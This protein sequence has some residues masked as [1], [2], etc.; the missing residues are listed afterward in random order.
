MAAR[1][2]EGEEYFT[3]IMQYVHEPSRRCTQELIIKR[4]FDLKPPNETSWDVDRFLQANR[5]KIVNRKHKN[6]IF[7]PTGKVQLDTLDI[8]LL[9]IL[10]LNACSLKHDLVT[11][12]NLVIEIRNK[13]SHPERFS[14]TPA[15]Y[16][17]FKERCDRFIESSLN[18]I[19]DDTLSTEVR[20]DVAAIEKPIPS[21]IIKAYNVSKREQVCKI[22]ELQGEFE[23]FKEA[24][25]RDIQENKEHKTETTCTILVKHCDNE[26]EKQMSRAV[27][28]LFN[29]GLDCS[30]ENC[31]NVVEAVE[32][33]R[34]TDYGPVSNGKVACIQLDIHCRNLRELRKLFDDV[35]S[36]K[37]QDLIK[38][39][40][41][42]LRKDF[43]TPELELELIIDRVDFWRCIYETGEII[44]RILENDS[45]IGNVEGQTDPDPV[46]DENT[47]QP[48]KDELDS[49]LEHE[50]NDDDPSMEDY[51]EAPTPSTGETF[52]ATSASELQKQMLQRGT[53]SGHLIDGG[54]DIENLK[55]LNIRP[56]RMT[57]VKDITGEINRSD[58]ESEEENSICSDYESSDAE[59]EEHMAFS[60]PD[61]TDLMMKKRSAEKESQAYNKWTVD[62][63]KAAQLNVTDHDTVRDISSCAHVQRNLSSRAKEKETEN[64]NAKIVSDQLR[65]MIQEQED[66]P[67][68]IVFVKARA[69]CRALA[70]YI[71]RDL[72]DMGVRAS[73]LHGQQT[74]GADQGMTESVQTETVEKFREGHYNVMVCT[75]VGT[76][77]IDVPDCNIVVNYNYSGDEITK[78]QMKGRSRNKGA[79]HVIVGGDK[80]VEQEMVNAYK[81]NLMYKAMDE[82]K[83]LNPKTIGYKVAIYQREEMQKHRYKMEYEKANKSKMSEDDLEI[84]CRRCNTKVCHVSDIRK[85]G[86]DHLVLDKSFANRFTTKPHITPKKYDGIEKKSKMICKKCPMDW[87]IVAERDGVDLWILKIQC[88]KFRNMRSADVS[89]YKKWIEVPYAV[90]E[91]TLE[92]IPKFFGTVDEVA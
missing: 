20:Q 49:G 91:M 45:S 70:E 7:P 29:K 39:L 74:R 34:T 80:Q 61:L 50:N 86:H 78:I 42:A 72:R 33:M 83:R 65:Q 40:E 57:L 8:S 82:F 5:D 35:I 68:A 12:L 71:D 88:F 58:E 44:E 67:R 75:S 81:A 14:L 28:N 6:A 43:N 25:R 85:L 38:P 1:K 36:G 3:R 92:D 13:I 26:K 59:K 55:D 31:Q 2:E 37:I 46:R 16:D 48:D 63:E 69:T 79:T 17:L 60:Q 19:E 84:L 90:P 22:M 89:A 23:E 76:E 10:I 52:E 24:Y 11:S 64:P 87:G 21:E 51:I 27:V 41:S 32:A 66:D 9:S 56:E 53:H 73:P 62:L 77:G 30:C 15:E 18:F 54:S 47:A 4:A